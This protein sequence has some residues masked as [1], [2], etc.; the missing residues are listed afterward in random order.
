MPVL[1]GSVAGD[2]VTVNRVG[3]PASNAVGF[4]TPTAA[5]GNRLLRGLGAPTVKSAALLLA[6]TVPFPFRSAAVVLLK[7]AVG[8]LP[9]KQL[10]PVPKPTKSAMFAV[11]HVPVSVVVFVT[12]ATLPAV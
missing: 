4:A 10:V 3:V 1:G 8:P 5:K 2:T 12:S 6:S 9:S 11:G 7:V